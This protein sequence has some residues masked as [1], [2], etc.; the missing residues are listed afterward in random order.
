MHG[1]E[2]SVEALG[3]RVFCV[4]CR[5]DVFGSSVMCVGVRL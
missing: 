4:G 1:S 2:F 5:G 3:V